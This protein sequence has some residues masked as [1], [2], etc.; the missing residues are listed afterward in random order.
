MAYLF[1][2][3]IIVLIAVGCVYACKIAEVNELHKIRA[4]FEDKRNVLAEHYKH[5]ED[6]KSEEAIKEEGEIQG[7]DD[8]IE[9]AKELEHLIF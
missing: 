5:L 9:I 3:L 7:L 1:I 2:G 6:N 8:A 4:A